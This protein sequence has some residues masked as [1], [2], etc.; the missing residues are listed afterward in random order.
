MTPVVY[1]HFTKRLM[2]NPALNTPFFI[3][4]VLE[5]LRDALESESCVELMD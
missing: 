5:E 4:S 3:A 1:A 2:D